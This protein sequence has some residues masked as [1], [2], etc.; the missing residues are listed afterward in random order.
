[1]NSHCWEITRKLFDRLDKKSTSV[2]DSF[3]SGMI[4][5]GTGVQS[6]VLLGETQFMYFAQQ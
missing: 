4:L 3:I 2:T 5:Q 6:Q 1:M